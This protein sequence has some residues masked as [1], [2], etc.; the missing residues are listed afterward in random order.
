MY[1][2][3][4]TETQQY[5]QNT[6]NVSTKCVDIIFFNSTAATVFVDGFPVLAGATYEISGNENEINVSTYKLSFGAG[7]TGI[8]YVTRKKYV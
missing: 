7:N 8:V 1:T 2:K 3:F 6:L 4:V 5:D